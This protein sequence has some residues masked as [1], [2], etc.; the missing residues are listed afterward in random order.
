MKRTDMQ[1]S[2]SL[3][4]LHSH[5][6]TLIQLTKEEPPMSGRATPTKLPTTEQPELPKEAQAQLEM[7]K[8]Y[9]LDGE[10]SGKKWIRRNYVEGEALPY[11]LHSSATVIVKPHSREFYVFD[12]QTLVIEE[13]F[14]QEIRKREHKPFNVD[15]IRAY[16]TNTRKE[17]EKGRQPVA[18]LAAE[19]RRERAE[20]ERERQQARKKA[21]QEKRDGVRAVKR[22]EKLAKDLRQRRQ[23]LVRTGELELVELNSEIPAI[24]PHSNNA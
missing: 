1:W 9:F 13:P 18:Q 22:I 7:D 8:L 24:V 23:A 20:R 19:E 5:S 11:T 6:S 16:Y 15:S 10:N 12:K 17:L 4:T 21:R 2:P 14:E 3:S